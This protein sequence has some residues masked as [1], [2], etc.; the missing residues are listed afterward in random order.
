MNH[1]HHLLLHLR[2]HSTMSVSVCKR[3]RIRQPHRISPIHLRL[4]KRAMP[5][6]KLR[7]ARGAVESEFC[8]HFG[9]MV[10]A[11]VRG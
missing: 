9:V 6:F 4:P 10:R 7:S 1:N 5:R 11:G 8:C 3:T 2:T